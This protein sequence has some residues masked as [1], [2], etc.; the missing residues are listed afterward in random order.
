MSW[1]GWAGSGLASPEVCWW[2]C[3]WEAQGLPQ[4]ALGLL[5]WALMGC[6]AGNNSSENPCI[7]PFPVP[8]ES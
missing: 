8:L 4:E 3:G 1:L 5:W 6:A 7:L 2:L